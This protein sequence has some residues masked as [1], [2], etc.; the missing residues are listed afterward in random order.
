M[1]TVDCVIIGGG[2]SGLCAARYL[3]NLG[4]SVLVLEARDRLGG[5]TVRGFVQSSLA[6]AAAGLPGSTPQHTSKMGLES[7]SVART[8]A[9]ARTESCALLT[10]WAWTPFPRAPKGNPSLWY[11]F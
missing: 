10:A 6:P 2:L 8:W 9:A 5:R 1:S 4:I 11:A 7:I 3:T